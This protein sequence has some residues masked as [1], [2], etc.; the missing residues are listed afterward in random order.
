MRRRSASQSRASFWASVPLAPQA[1][2]TVTSTGLIQHRCA[3]V[4]TSDIDQDIESAVYHSLDVY[5]HRG[6]VHVEAGILHDL[7]VD[8]V[9]M[10][11]RLEHDP[12]ED[13][14]VARLHFYRAGEGHAE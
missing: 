7:G 2:P 4:A 5:R 12:R 14:G 3:H 6:R 13:D 8:A 11:P 1:R 10:G 9:A